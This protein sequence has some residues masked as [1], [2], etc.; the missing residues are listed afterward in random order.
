M[1][2]QPTPPRELHLP[3]RSKRRVASDVDAELAFHIARRTEELIEQ[4]L[5][6]DEA[7]REAAARFGNLE[8]TKQYC[9]DED[10]RR[11]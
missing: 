2:D 9:R 11:E 1:P 8:Y 3:S 10:V 4:G 7:R 6:A 5:S